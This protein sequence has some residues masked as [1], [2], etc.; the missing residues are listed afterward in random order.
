[1]KT[2]VFLF[3]C[4]ATIGLA[5]CSEA[6]QSASSAGDAIEAAA[7]SAPS[8]AMTDGG[9]SADAASS[10]PR[11]STP[12]PASMPQLAYD[13]GLSYRLP[14]ADIGT[15]MRRH[16]NVCEQQGP[17]S[18]RIIGMDLSGEAE[19]DS[20]RGTLQLAVAAP[21]ARAVSALLEK[22]AGDMDAEQ[23]KATIG[24]EEVSKTIVDSEARIR[25]RQELRDRL[26]E[27]L[28]TREG[29]V[30]ELVEAER[31]VAEVNEEIDQAK[32]WLAET[33]G[34][35]AFSR[36]DIDYAPGTG[37]ASEFMAPIEGALGSLGG[38]LGTLVAV[39]LVL[40]AIGLPL[41]G[42]IAGLVWLRRRLAAT[43]VA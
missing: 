11:A 16:A 28:R 23:V 43:A 2:K 24:S 5:A 39:L 32:S 19:N 8:D 27:V 42:A 6:E 31:N 9:A 33:K 30:Q 26:T 18:C 3:V 7:E 25:A 41:G 4:V 34:R 14:S 38:I 10:D 13:Y 1:M 29:S 20:V 37:A 21:H 36:M 15:L 40:L 22:E 12:I 17:A 35:V